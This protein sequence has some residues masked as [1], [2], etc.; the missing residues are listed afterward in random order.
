MPTKNI[1]PRGEG[2]GGLGRIDKP[3]DS[4][5][6]L[7]IPY[8]SEH[9]DSHNSTASSIHIEGIS[10][11]AVAAREFENPKKINHV[12]FKG[13]EDI[14]IPLADDDFMNEQDV[15]DLWNVVWGS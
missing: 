1:V 3:W 10:G 12:L 13:S 7:D 2:E 9:V 8:I 4:I 14:E 11:G 15:I 6:A 5:Y